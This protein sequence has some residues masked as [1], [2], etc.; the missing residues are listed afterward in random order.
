MIHCHDDNKQFV[1]LDQYLYLNHIY[2]GTKDWRRSTTTE[3]RKN[4]TWKKDL[5]Y[6]EQPFRTKKNKV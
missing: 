4:L 2:I 1:I 6:V 3:S 5:F